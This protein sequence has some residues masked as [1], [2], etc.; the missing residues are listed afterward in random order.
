MGLRQYARHRERLGL[1]GATLRAV[2]VAI[3]SGRLMASVTAGG[4]IKTARAADAEWASSTN[5]DRVPLTGPTAPAKGDAPAPP[6]N[7]LAVARAR[8]EA[9]LAELAEI[10]LAQK[11]GELI[12]ARDVEARLADVFLRCRTRLLGIPARLREQDPT[13]TAAQLGLIEN[14]IR[15]SL[16]E[17]AGGEA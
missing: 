4:K 9:T 16:E 12:R 17:L 7:E 15:G 14:L 6:V 5:A 8:R 1:D 11:R 3:K 10:E 13:L 2:Q